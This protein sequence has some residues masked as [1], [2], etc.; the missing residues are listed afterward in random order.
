M[1]RSIIGLI[2]V[3]LII[4]GLFFLPEIMGMFGL[5]S[6]DGEGAL[7][8]EVTEEYYEEE[9]IDQL[10]D[11]EDGIVE[12]QY[13]EESVEVVPTQT[14]F[15]DLLIPREGPITWETLEDEEIVE[16][17]E[18]VDKQARE[19]VVAVDPERNPQVRYE[20]FHFISAIQRLRAG[21]NNKIVGPFEALLNADYA[22]QAVTRAMNREGADRSLVTAWS[23]ISLA[24]I[25][26]VPLSYRLK[27]KLSLDYNPRLQ[28]VEVGVTHD[29]PKRDQH[30]RDAPIRVVIEGFI[31]GDDTDYVQW[32]LG[33]REWEAR[34]VRLKKPDLVGRRYFMVKNIQHAKGK[35]LN[36][37]AVS[38]DKK[39]FRKS[40]A[41][42]PRVTRFPVQKDDRGKL[43]YAVPF[44]PADP[45]IDRFFLLQQLR[46][47]PARIEFR[48]DPL[49]QDP[50]YTGNEAP[51]IVPF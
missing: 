43:T 35:A 30:F 47:D 42:Y 19:L 10:L 17:L 23:G 26:R 46:Y 8:G 37:L 32:Y 49:S 15:P 44:R 25:L 51:P 39:A 28:L 29:R 41:V 12:E 24:P 2:V 11:P 20:L 4:G 9:S 31:V 7:E 13:V 40:Y 5:S 16:L 21:D 27:Q 45:R 36:F 18:D 14:P 6:G 38:K 3:G 50:G 34:K 22:D 48:G 1:S 33:N